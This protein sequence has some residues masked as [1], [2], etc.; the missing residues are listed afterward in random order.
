MRILMCGAGRITR[1][2]LKVLGSG[3]KVTII[4]KQEKSTK[5][6]ASIFPNVVETYVEDAT[7][8]V[9]LDHADMKRHDY[10]LALMS[11]DESNLA[12][13]RQAVD[14]GVK[15]VLSVVR[16]PENMEK[17]KGLDIRL[18]PMESIPANSILHYL[19]DLGIH[20]S[21]LV[22]GEASVFELD[23]ADHFR[24]V[25]RPASAF[26]G[27]THRLVGI[28]RG[29]ELVFPD[30]STVI[31]S[32]DRL[33]VIG[34]PETFRAFCSLIECGNPHFPLAYGQGL[35]LAL[36]T[37]T[38]SDLSKLLSKGLY[39]A[40]NTRVKRATVLCPGECGVEDLAKEWPLDISL[41]VQRVEEGN[42][43]GAVRD[44]YEKGKYG[45]VVV[46][47]LER[48]FLRQFGKPRLISLSHDL[49]CPVLV[50]R[51]SIPYERILVPFNGTAR[52]EQ[53]LG[54]A[55][56]I[57]RQLECAITVTVV[58]EPEIISGEEEGAGTER[59]LARVREL[60]RIHKTTLEEVV[61]RGNP[62]KELVKLSGSHDLLIIGS[63]ST[64][65]GIFSA[66][67]GEH[68]AEKATCSVLIVAG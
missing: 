41:S 2:L 4:D 65:K 68:V 9:V 53:A 23:A 58:E 25:G 14:A 43:L 55:V 30:D 61:R 36:P 24:I 13:A 49:G 47:P 17:F 54:I 34:K 62:V 48:S 19:Q 51:F 42:I 50:A 66:N 64:E 7:S 29:D 10:V 16:D 18:V 44:V 31:S 67:V 52:A 60:S 63:T 8:P 38:Y 40:Q 21:P 15:H 20:V 12:V 5:A 57:A 33:V 37:G 3:W 45:L 35:L 11:D 59:I 39:L 56:D 27:D 26:N 22:N 32:D 6:A 28:L 46:P 1:E